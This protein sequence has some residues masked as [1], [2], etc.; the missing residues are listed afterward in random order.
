MRK[1]EKEITNRVKIYDILKRGKYTIL[2][3][4]RDNEPYVVTLSYGVR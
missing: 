1:I 3:L 4:C 2:S